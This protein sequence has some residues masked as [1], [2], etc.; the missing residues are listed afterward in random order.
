MRMSTPCLE[1]KEH[2]HPEIQFIYPKNLFNNSKVSF[3]PK[4]ENTPYLFHRAACVPSD[5]QECAWSTKII[6][7]S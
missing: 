2:I 5:Y 3:H 6:G 1:P 4:K 7:F